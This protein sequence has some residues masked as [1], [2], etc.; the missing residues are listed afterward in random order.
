M[1]VLKRC[2]GRHHG[3]F[4]QRTRISFRSCATT[5]AQ[6]LVPQEM[7]RFRVFLDLTTLDLVR[8]PHHAVVRAN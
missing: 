6:A 7:Q 4:R 5:S 1:F 8:D 2:P 3:M